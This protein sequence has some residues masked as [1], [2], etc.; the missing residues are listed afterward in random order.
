MKEQEDTKTLMGRVALSS[1]LA[2]VHMEGI[3]WWDRSPIGTPLSFSAFSGVRVS[4]TES[5]TCPF[6]KLAQGWKKQSKSNFSNQNYHWYQEAQFS[7]QKTKN[8]AEL[9]AR[10]H[11]ELPAVYISFQ[12]ILWAACWWKALDLYQMTWVRVIPQAS[13]TWS[14]CEFLN[15]SELQF[16]SLVEWGRWD[17]THLSLGAARKLE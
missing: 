8:L 5:S 12:L 16:I 13:L 9:C 6:C 4:T 14:L 10:I 2:Q 7:S 15:F 11:T 17:M 1:S 3:S